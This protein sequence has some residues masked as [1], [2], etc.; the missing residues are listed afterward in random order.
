MGEASVSR[1]GERTSAR[2]PLR[3]SEA[4]FRARLHCCGRQQSRQSERHV[5]EA[6]AIL[7]RVMSEECTTPDLVE[8]VRRWPEAL[9]RRDFDA[10]EGHLAPDAVVVLAQDRDVRR[11][12][13][14]TR[15][16]RRLVGRV[17][18]HR[19][20]LRGGPRPRQRVVVLTSLLAILLAGVLQIQLGVA[21]AKSPVR[22]HG[23]ETQADKLAKALKAC[24]EKPKKAKKERIA[25]EKRARKKYRPASSRHPRS[26]LAISVF[27]PPVAPP[28]NQP[29]SVIP[30]EVPPQCHP[31]ASFRVGIQ[32]DNVFLYNRGM[33][34]E[35]G[36]ATAKRLLGADLLRINIIYGAWVSYG[37]QAYL[38]AARAAVAQGFVVQANLVGTPA[39]WPQLS[40]TLSYRNMDP[41]TMKQWSQEVV[42]TLGSLVNRYAVWNEPN[43]SAFGE[44]VTPE[45]YKSLFMGAYAGIKA[46]NSGA[47][48][49]ADELSPWAENEWLEATRS[50]PATADAIHPYSQT[51]LTAHFLA[52]AGKELDETEYGNPASDPNQAAENAQGL[53]D[54][55]CGGASMLIFYQLVRVPTPGVWD[56]GIVE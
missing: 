27:G 1:V 4:G 13:S 36:F 2:R 41:E 49:I 48:V 9:E 56:T 39:Y 32:D 54:A 43:W 5:R 8:M 18:G 44:N 31:V 14:N 34:R 33:T 52:V 53:E 26:G 30:V 3:S 45:E 40:Q 15:L 50:L 37:P 6:S 12:G 55:K 47:S 29:I 24:K 7:G 22:G 51:N 42:G 21:Q 20:G 19:G 35:E 38:E 11:H 23:S 28:L 16:L 46:A 10:V 25:C 17:R